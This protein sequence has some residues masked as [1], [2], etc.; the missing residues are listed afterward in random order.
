MNSIT[1]NGRRYTEMCFVR[2]VTVL[3]DD[4]LGTMTDEE[5]IDLMTQLK[6]FRFTETYHPDIHAE[7][8]RLVW[9]NETDALYVEAQE[10]LCD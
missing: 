6:D 2:G 10:E 4:D 5:L 1:V 3:T 9:N 7:N 8:I